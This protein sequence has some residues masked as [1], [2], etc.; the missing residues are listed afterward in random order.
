MKTLR[1][2][3]LLLL[4]LPGVATLRAQPENFL[5][6]DFQFVRPPKWEWVETKIK[7]Q[8]MLKITSS[9]KVETAEVSFM[10]FKAGDPYGTLNTTFFRWRNMFDKE[11]RVESRTLKKIGT[12]EVLFADVR[13]PYKEAGSKVYSR[14]D[15]ALFGVIIPSPN[16]NVGVRIIGPY[17]LVQE[18]RAE[19]QKMIENAI[20]S[21]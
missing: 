15:T 10:R 2:A 5:V 13:G 14:A 20:L 8:P 4:L 6:G 12:H 7:Q 18:S 9:N 17:S 3:F 19:F 11:Q 1:G 16:G 21:E